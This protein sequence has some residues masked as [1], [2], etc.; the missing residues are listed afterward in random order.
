[1]PQGK[2]QTRAGLLMGAGAILLWSSA[3]SAV[4]LGSGLMGRWQ[5]MALACGAG[6][7]L[8]LAFYNRVLGMS[9]GRLLAPPLRIWPMVLLGF[10][11]YQSL[12]TN[13]VAM[14]HKE[15]VAGVALTNYLWPTLTILLAIVLVPGTRGSWRLAAAMTLSAAGLVVA[16]WQEIS[17]HAS[18]AGGNGASLWP[19]VLAALAAL[20]WATYCALL[21]R[22][23]S[24]TRNYATSPVGFL[25]VA[26]IAAIVCAARGEWVAMEGR[27]WLIVCLSGLGPYGGGYLL[28]ELSLHRAPTDKLGLLAAATPVLATLGL[29]V[30][31]AMCPMNRPPTSS[32]P[33]FLI[34]AAMI[35]AAV[36]LGVVGKSDTH[37]KEPQA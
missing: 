7:I 32:Y 3:A 16:N 11:I 24:W 25:A 26:A 15:Q 10:V 37:V 33:L 4:L 6:G 30:V 9:I 2:S 29:C 23:K 35:A 1:M 20:V 19:Y 18:S 21:A 36:L 34:G 5:F 13:A 28:W 8:Q 22:W 12:W 14:S 17:K 31:F 27:S